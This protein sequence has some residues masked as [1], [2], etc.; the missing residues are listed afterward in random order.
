MSKNYCYLMTTKTIVVFAILAIALTTTIGMMDPAFARAITSTSTALTVSGTMTTDDDSTYACT[1]G[2]T[3]FTQTLT[4]FND[5]TG[6]IV[7]EWNGAGCSDV[8]T[9]LVEIFDSST[10][11]YDVLHT[12]S[13]GSVEIDTPVNN[14]DRI[15]AYVTFY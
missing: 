7:V 9:V 15:R 13:S 2:R 12:N 4:V 8:Q 3:E 11:V 1:D 10:K 5:S 6:T 14:G